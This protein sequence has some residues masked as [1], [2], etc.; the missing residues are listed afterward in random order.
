MNEAKVHTVVELGGLETKSTESLLCDVDDFEE[1]EKQQQQQKQ[2]PLKNSLSPRQMKSLVALCDTLLPSI[3]DNNVVASSD[4][5][6][7][8]FYRTSAS[9][10]G[11]P[12]RSE[13]KKVS[14]KE[15][16]KIDD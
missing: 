5:Y 10:A 2:L 8:N 6:V 1:S 3:I 15:N 16:M 13:G 4:E 9:M 14:M 12:E 11:T 7:N